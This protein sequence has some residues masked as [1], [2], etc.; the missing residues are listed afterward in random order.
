M[1]EVSNSDDDKS[2]LPLPSE[3]GIVL[4]PYPKIVFL[5]PSW[6]V[7]LIAGSYLY[8]SAVAVD[9]SAAVT[10][11]WLFLITLSINL[12]VLAFDFPRATSFMVLLFVVAI[13]LGIGMAASSYPNLLPS[14]SAF[15][16][17]F[18]PQA[19]STF[20]FIFFIVMTCIFIVVAITARFDYWEVRPNELLHHHGVLSDMK[21]Y[22]SPHLRVDKEINDLFEYFLLGSGRLILHPSDERRA[23]VLDNVFFINSKEK[24]VTK[25]LGA[26]Q[27]QVR[28]KS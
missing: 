3:K 6:V 8:F 9:S 26:L 2:N 27:V 19:N 1:I 13:G 7:S 28:E 14:I 4:V 22:S 20:Y 17:S 18:H 25:L 10:M 5:W 16:K 15:F 21:R 11:G 24:A 12:I 23:I